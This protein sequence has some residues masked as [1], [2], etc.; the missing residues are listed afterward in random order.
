MSIS[1]VHIL[2]A[3]GGFGYHSDIR[4]GITF[5]DV[6]VHSWFYLFLAVLSREKLLDASN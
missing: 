4:C 2:I 6:S 3:G 5:R 1:K